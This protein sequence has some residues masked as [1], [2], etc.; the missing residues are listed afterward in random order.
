MSRS[1]GN[2]SCN[3]LDRAKVPDFEV[4]DANQ[5]VEPLLEMKQQFDKLLRIENPSVQQVGGCRL[6]IDM[7]YLGK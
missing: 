7:E 1:L 3:P 6:H 5:Y 4:L 2:E